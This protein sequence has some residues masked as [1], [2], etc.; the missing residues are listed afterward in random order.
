[1]KSSGAVTNSSSGAR[2]EL[3][4][5]LG[6][7][8]EQLAAPAVEL[9]VEARQQR[10]RALGEHLVLSL[11]GRSCDLDSGSSDHVS[12]LPGSVHGYSAASIERASSSSGWY[13][14]RAR[15][16]DPCGR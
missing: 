3:G 15:R 14:G 5:A 11:L 2:V 16:G 13:T 10:E 6:A 7:P 4:L 8:F 9:A 12:S 1:M